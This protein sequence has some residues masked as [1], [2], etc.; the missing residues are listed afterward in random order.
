VSAPEPSPPPG[1]SLLARLGWA[2]K[3]RLLGRG[4]E[5]RAFDAVKLVH[6][7][8]LRRWDRFPRCQ[9]FDGITYGHYR[10]EARRIELLRRSVANLIDAG[11]RLE[12]LDS[13][14]TVEYRSELVEIPRRVLLRR[15]VRRTL[16]QAPLAGTWVEADD[17]V[18]HGDVLEVHAG[19]RRRWARLSYRGPSR[20]ANAERI[21]E[22]R[23]LLGRMSA[24]QRAAVEEVATSRYRQPVLFV[25]H[26]WEDEAQPDPSGS[27]LRQLRALKDCFIVYDYTSFPQPPRS[28]AEQADFDE[29]LGA[30]EELVRRV[31]I[32]EAPD[33]LTRG[34]C[35]Y[36][37]VV[38][39]LRRT[40]VCDGVSDERFVTLRDWASTPPPASLSFRD[41][42][43]SQQQNYINEQILRAANEV[44]P[45]YRDAEFVSEHD[46]R[47]VTGLLIDHLQR[48]L[49]PI[50]E[51]QQ[52]LG[53]WK[54]TQWTA[55][56]L[57]PFF[58]GRGEVPRLESGV[59]IKRFYTA[60]PSSI[61]EAVSRRYEIKCLDWEARLN[62]LDSLIRTDLGSLFKG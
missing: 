47:V 51:S 19:L 31:L 43:E 54:T 58:S 35:V 52:Y 3:D 48:C 6:A 62:P 45:L 22:L 33:Y 8:D 14:A 21:E 17:G 32:L 29:I 50:K 23:N 57:E 25:S 20:I 34:W 44:L 60:V 4:D 55:E 46:R 7:D 27:Q 53:E 13:D 5:A 15:R 18:V 37:Y 38:A 40:T 36:E 9:E 56:R 59:P 12:Q 61:A 10:A 41:S 24:E 42:Y 2:V 49:P 26:R 1:S 11:E 28:A 16:P 30:M 39:S